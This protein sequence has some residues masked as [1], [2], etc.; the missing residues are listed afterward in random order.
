VNKA[1]GRI[2]VGRGSRVMISISAKM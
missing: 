1:I 2:I